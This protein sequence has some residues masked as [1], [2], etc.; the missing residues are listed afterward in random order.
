MSE[1]GVAAN[2]DRAA[3]ADCAA[4][5][6]IDSLRAQGAAASDPVR[7]RFIEALAARAAAADGGARRLI[8]ERIAVLLADYRERFAR[9]QVEARASLERAVARFSDFPDSVAEL[10]SA[11]AE[12]DFAR[13]RQLVAR[14]ESRQRSSA[15]ADLLA[16]IERNAD[17]DGTPSAAEESDPPAVTRVMKRSELK[18][19]AYFRDTWVKLRVDRQLAQ[20]FAQ[21]PENA[22]PLNSHRLMLQALQSM[23]EASPDYLAR[24]MAWAEALLWLE[25][26]DIGR[27]PARENA[28]VRGSD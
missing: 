23:R 27:K 19:I 5:A 7:W 21:A 11:C 14:L 28:A 13:L 25:Q 24:F 17:A 9:A 3:V 26:A 20:A 6:A 1:A 4:A 8:D 15:L 18:S 22:G 12:A 16:H 2:P 10:E